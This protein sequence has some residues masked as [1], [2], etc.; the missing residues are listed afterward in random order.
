MAIEYKMSD[1][2]VLS[3][4]RAQIG[5]NSI[6]QKG[7]FFEPLRVFELDL[8]EDFRQLNNRKKRGGGGRRCRIAITI[9]TS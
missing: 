1:I 4:L 2:D 7:Q 3:H 8:I 6:F 9:G 5:S